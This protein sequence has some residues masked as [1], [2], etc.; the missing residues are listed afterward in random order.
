MIRYVSIPFN[1]E[2]VSEL[3]L[4][5]APKPVVSLFLFPSTGKAFLNT[6]HAYSNCITTAIEFLFPSTGKAFPNEAVSPI[7]WYPNRF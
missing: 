4:F 7:L 5:T 1:R 2:G 6:P 3:N